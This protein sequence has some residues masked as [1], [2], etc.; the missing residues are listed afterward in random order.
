MRGDLQ[1]ECR[2][3]HQGI[4]RAASR[5]RTHELHPRKLRPDPHS[6]IFDEQLRRDIDKGLIGA[7]YLPAW[8]KFGLFG[9]TARN[10]EE[11]VRAYSM[12]NYPEEGD[13]HHA[14]VR[15]ATPPFKPKP[16]V[17]FQ[18]VPA[19]IASSYIFSLKPGDKVLMSGP[20]GD[21][22][23]IVD[24]QGRDDLGGRRCRYG[25]LR[26]QIMWMTKTL[27]TTDRKMSYFYGAG[28]STEVFYLQGFPPAGERFPQLQ[29]PSRPG[30]LPTRR[31]TQPASDT[32][33][34]LFTT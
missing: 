27:H 9:L 20:H 24:F 13:P 11:T 33:P 18:D 19:G 14:L 31:P 32:P 8:E 34:D 22:H 12:A 30:P 26:A 5:G 1:Q 21:F 17:G 2:D 6:E 3:I 10:D 7:E 23:P 16:Q 25:S 28:H 29:V 4:H 15:I